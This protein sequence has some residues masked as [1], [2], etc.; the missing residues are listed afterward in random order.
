MNV[1]A[2]RVAALLQCLFMSCVCCSCAKNKSSS[3]QLNEDFLC[4]SSSVLGDANTDNVDFERPRTVLAFVL[5]HVEHRSIVSPTERYYYYRFPLRDRMVS[6]NIRFVDAEVGAISVGYFDANNASDLRVGNFEDGQDGIKVRLNRADN[7]V[8]LDVDGVRRTFHLDQSALGSPRIPLMEGEHI[9][10]GVRDESGYYLYLMYWQPGRAFYYVLQSDK[11]RPESWS[12][13]RTQ[14]CE[15][16]FGDESRFCFLR[17]PTTGRF[18]LVG[19]LRRNIELNNWYD[20]PF[21]QVPPYL[22]IKQTLEEA[23]PY[24]LDAGGIDAHGNFITREGQ[25]VAISPYRDYSSGPQLAKDIEEL[26]GPVG[27]PAYW[28][29]ITYEYKR[30]WRAPQYPVTTGHSAMTSSA[31]PANHW[32]PSSKLWSADH[33]SALSVTWPANHS[34]AASGQPP[35]L[36]PNR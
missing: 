11:P 36:E 4:R 30:D 20:G 7:E 33:S 25:R 17:E 32:G 3:L 35:T 10:S 31:W 21:D 12:R 22:P 18:V 26:V 14:K 19:V 9:I 29:K 16:W 6:G 2:I 34:L 23:Y 8:L 24:V 27:T 15:L 13:G 5:S 1:I 28:T